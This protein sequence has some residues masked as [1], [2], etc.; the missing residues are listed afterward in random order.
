[1]VL[2]VLGVLLFAGV[3]F[4]PSLAPAVKNSWTGKLGENG[5]KGVFSLLLL[6]SFA[7]MILGWRSAQPAFVYAPPPALHLPSLGLMYLAFFLL[8][9]SNRPSRLRLLVRHPQLTGVA[10]W[11]VAHLLLNGDSR[12]L[13][14]FGGM[15]AWAVLEILAIN[16]RDGQWTREPAP[17]ISADVINVA[18]AAVAVV[19]VIALHPWLSGVAVR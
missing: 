15:T 10:L 16:R 9:I 6:A 2:L 18:I 19:V 7:L 12:S 1:M 17:A 5:Y 14:L 3:H 8:V 4:I 13:V 11:G